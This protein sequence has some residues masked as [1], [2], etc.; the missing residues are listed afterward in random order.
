MDATNTLKEVVRMVKSLDAD[1]RAIGT[2][3]KC[4][5]PLIGIVA[6]GKTAEQ[7]G[8]CGCKGPTKCRPRKAA[9]AR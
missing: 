2:C 6:M 1:L 3:E 7:A 5:L 9:G 8:L 4:G